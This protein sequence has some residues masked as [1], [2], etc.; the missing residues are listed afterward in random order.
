M[1]GEQKTVNSGRWTVDRD[2]GREAGIW[3]GF[4]ARGGV[5][6]SLKWCVVSAKRLL[7]WLHSG[8]KCSLRW[9]QKFEGL[10]LRETEIGEKA[11]GN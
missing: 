6:W 7:G 5:K 3:L 9:L 2:E 1:P 11:A 10:T 4:G 8:G